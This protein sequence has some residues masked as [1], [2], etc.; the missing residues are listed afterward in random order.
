MKR[1]TT[2]FGLTLL[3]SLLSIVA[4][5]QE[6][7][8]NEGYIFKDIKEIKSTSVKDQQRS[9]TCWS[10]SGLAL[11]ES[12]IIK[13]GKPEVDL[14]PMFVVR[15]AY[16]DKATK[17]VR[18]HGNLNFAGGGS[19]YDV[20]ETIK[21]YG[22]VPESVYKG[23]E[24]GEEMNVHGELDE[25]TKAYV[26]AV[27]KNRN[28]KLSTAWKI[29]FDGILDAYFGNIPENFNYNGTQYTPKSFLEATGLNLDDYIY[30]S[31]FTHHP[32]YTKFI[33]EVP[34]NWAYGEVYNLPLDEF[35]GV[36]D[37]AIDNGYCIAWASDVS[38]K[39]FSYNN[40]IAIIP[41]ANVADMTD[42]EKAKWTELSTREKEAMLYTFDKPGKEKEI[43]QDMRQLA[44][45]NY[46]TTDDHGM[47]IVGIAQDQNGTKYYK[48]KNSWGTG[49]KYNG[50][51][52]ASDAFI[53]YKTMS[54][55]VNKNALPKSIKKKLGL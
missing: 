10:Y 39:G 9:G 1:Y 40:G 20:I 3:L 22:I 47:L 4:F 29:G 45:D 36:F 14:S 35:M 46:T 38:E 42:S 12:E 13:M 51:F 7:Q 17:Y 5:S 34:D 2:L 55:M 8:K 44:F 52:Y 37:N 43:T 15:N 28:R 25:V 23:L 33:I 54:I 50:F 41:E 32:F 21:R 49:G 27:I 30:I 53:R 11:L 16:S 24:Y 6:E 19:F 31:S 26:D 18:F 48:V